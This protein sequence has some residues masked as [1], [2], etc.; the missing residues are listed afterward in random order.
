MKSNGA[1]ML[2]D[3]RARQRSPRRN[4]SEPAQQHRS[5]GAF[6]RSGGGPFLIP[7][8]PAVDIPYTIANFRPFSMHFTCCERGGGGLLAVSCRASFFFRGGSA[9]DVSIDPGGMLNAL[10][11]RGSSRIPLPS[12]GRGSSMRNTWYA[13][14]EAKK[15]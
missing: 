7:K 8:W 2:M 3:S 6:F 13:Y 10:L 11:L 4:S 14:I 15:Q 9:G 1:K 12:T 5:R